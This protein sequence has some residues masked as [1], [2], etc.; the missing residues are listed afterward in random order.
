MSR[1]NTAPHA[2]ASR[3]NRLG[4]WAGLSLPAA[5]LAGMALVG[6]LITGMVPGAT[7]S[8]QA[9]APAAEN[10]VKVVGLAVGR[11]VENRLLIGQSDRFAADGGRLWGH[12]V[13][14]NPG[15]ATTVTM[16]WRR[17]E[18]ERYRAELAVGNS[19]AWRTWTR[20]TPSVKRDAGAWSLEVL[21]AAGAT[22][23]TVDFE[24]T[25]PES[26]ELGLADP[27]EGESG[28]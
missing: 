21:D 9:A 5:G 17:G 25:A 18:K 15:P 20:V 28:C 12:V 6:A 14:S 7:H 19:P 22:L 11:G 4:L 26:T 2:P 1:S 24:V 13:V 10:A 16:V 3:R 8:A 27:T 23:A